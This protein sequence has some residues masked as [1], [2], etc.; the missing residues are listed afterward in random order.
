MHEL[1]CVFTPGT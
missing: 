1:C